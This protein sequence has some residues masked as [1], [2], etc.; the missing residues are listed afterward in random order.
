MSKLVKRYLGL[1]EEII[2][3]YARL[4]D[5]CPNNG[6]LL[7]IRLNDGGQSFEREKAFLHSYPCESKAI[8]AGLDPLRSYCKDLKKACESSERRSKS[9]LEAA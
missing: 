5:T 2:G 7:L 1:V 3:H 8:D 4:K 9:K 6:L